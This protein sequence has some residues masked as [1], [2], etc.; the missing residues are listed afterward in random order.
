MIFALPGS[1]AHNSPAGVGFSDGVYVTRVVG[2]SNAGWEVYSGAGD[3]KVSDMV[4]IW[5]VR[6]SWDLACLICSGSIAK[7]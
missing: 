4:F 6:S 5:G 7:G 1:G 3:A 2:H